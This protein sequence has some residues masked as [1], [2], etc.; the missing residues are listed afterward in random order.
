MKSNEEKIIDDAEQRCSRLYMYELICVSVFLLTAVAFAATGKSVYFFI[1]VAL[2]L[3][4]ISLEIDEAVTRDRAYSR[5]NNRLKVLNKSMRR[6]VKR[7]GCDLLAEETAE[8]IREYA[9]LYIKTEVSEKHGIISR[10]GKEYEFL[11]EE[12]ENDQ[13]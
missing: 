7:I 3:V 6:A 11:Y 8:Y 2:I 13:A 5:V 1:S 9:F 12:D 10:F 4:S